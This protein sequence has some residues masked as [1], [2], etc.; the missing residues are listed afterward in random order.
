[1]WLNAEVHKITVH[2]RPVYVP[3]L[4]LPLSLFL[5]Y[6]LYF[7]SG[8]TFSYGNILGHQQPQDYLI[9]D[10]KSIFTKSS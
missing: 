2:N 10:K 6:S 9:P 1:M 4:P 8:K 3:A 7:I 5:L